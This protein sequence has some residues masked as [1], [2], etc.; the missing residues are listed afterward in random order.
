[1][2]SSMSYRVNAVSQ[3]GRA[4]SFSS[5][6]CKAK[7]RSFRKCWTISPACNRRREPWA[8]LLHSAGLARAAADHLRV[9]SRSRPLCWA[10]AMHP[11]CPPWKRRAHLV[12]K[13]GSLTLPAP[14]K[15]KMLDEKHSRTS[16]TG[17]ISRSVA[18]TIKV[19]VPE[20]AP[21]SPPVT[22][23]SNAW[24]PKPRQPRQ[25]RG[26]APGSWW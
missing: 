21:D 11:P 13:L 23:Q 10:N 24:R 17:S 25:C 1:M 22:G 15:Q 20:M 14:P 16:R 12:S 7:P 8:Q 3:P 26:Q 6:T 18:P 5:A 4:I 19:S 9:C 2:A